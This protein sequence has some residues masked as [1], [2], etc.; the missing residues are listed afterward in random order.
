MTHLPF[1]AR[2][3]AW[4]NER[5]YACVAGVPE[6]TYRRD[7]GL[8]FKSIH[9]T[10]NHIL[11]VDRMWIRRIEGAAHGLKSLD[12]VLYDDLAELRAAQRDEN[13]RLIALVGDLTAEDL[14]Q[15]IRYTRMIGTGEEE[16]R[17]DHVLLTLFNHQ[18]YHRGQVTAALTQA[19]VEPPPL[20]IG[21]YT[22]DVGLSGD[23][24]TV[25]AG[26]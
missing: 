11:V 1:M 13:A 20:D 10:L 15:P 23:P 22:E 17:C 21:F 7:C 8:F 25:K 24:G 12:E 5:L 4:A 6:E 2:F 9:G 16:A 26:A 14:T 19:G 18:T 3:T